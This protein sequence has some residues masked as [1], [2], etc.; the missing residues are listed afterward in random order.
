MIPNLWFNFIPVYMK[1]YKVLRKGA[2]SNQT[3]PR[4]EA[5]QRET[6][7]RAEAY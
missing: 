4:P 2:N 1:R 6:S 5:K 7:T 3:F